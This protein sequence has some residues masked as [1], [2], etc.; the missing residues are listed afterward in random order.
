MPALES[1]SR[2]LKAACASGVSAASEPPAT[3]A[4]ASPAW[5]IRSAAPIACAPEAQAEL[6]ANDGAAQVVAHRQRAG[7]GVA[8][9]QR[10]G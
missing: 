3:T 2:A 6:T 7:A 10:H 8:H 5:I 1:A 4:S 9:H